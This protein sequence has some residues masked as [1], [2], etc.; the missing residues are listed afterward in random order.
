MRPVINLKSFIP[1][2]TFGMLSIS[3]AKPAAE[4]E[5]STKPNIL[6][7][8]ADDMGYSD[9]GCYGSE[10]HTP[11]LDSL[12]AD[13]L[14]FTQFYNTSR[15]WSSRS[16]LLTGYYAQSIRRDAF[17]GIQFAQKI[18]GGAGGTR[19]RWAELLPEFLK[20]LGYHSYMSGKWHV[21]GHPLENGF[22]HDYLD[23]NGDGFFAQVGA[24]EDGK[25]LPKLMPGSGYYSTTAIAD[26][27]IK[28]LQE[29]AARHARQPFFAYVAFHSPH[30]PIQAL[31]EDIAIYQD[32]YKSGWDAMRVER[33]ERMKKMGI[34]N[35]DLSKLDPVTIPHW[36]LAESEL[37]RRIGPGE[38]GYAVPWDTLTP[39]QKKF[40]SAKM[41]VHAAM[42]HRMDLEI[43][44]VLD[45]V[46]AMRVYDDT[47]IVFVSDNGA[48]AEQI[49]RGL[50]EDPK[51]PIG[52]A[53]S[54]LGIGPGWASFCNTPLRLY[55]SWEDEGGIS[56][57][58][59]VHWPA[60]IH[61]KGE[62]RTNP[63]H[64]IDILPT[65]L[66]IA[67]G[68]RPDQLAG[69]DVP[70][71][72]GKSLVPVFTKDGSVVHDYLWWNHDGNRAIRIGDWKLVADH[73]KPWELFNLSTDRSET[74]NL[75]SKYPEKLKEL[76]QA[77]VQHAEELHA[78][79]LQDLPPEQR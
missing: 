69:L 21:D 17:T 77:W 20:P 59:I 31:P 42:V 11:N 32:R 67:G 5:K 54:Y 47:L 53:Y 10:I 14:R 68:T 73:Q 12:A 37:Q 27:A 19:P 7:F 71:L 26:Y 13:G 39:G 45:Q 40:Q 28:Y 56:T 9:A 65:V 18:N 66:D 38:V 25:A 16:C 61:A 36:N 79:A 64:L 34:V 75:A 30:F 35:C 46:K 44:R 2:L 29:H 50:G 51:A 55:K 60:G 43:G 70:P 63:G 1:I 6:F 22:E 33:F 52:S 57:P 78:L 72:P 4:A 3:A 8:V 24:T 62:L 74:K 58:L 49:I 48:S 15:C 76:D 23:M 41:A